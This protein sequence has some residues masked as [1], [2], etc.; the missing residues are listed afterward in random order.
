MGFHW[1]HIWQ[2]LTGGS[3]PGSTSGAA[4]TDA[5][6]ALL[7][8]L[9]LSKKVPGLSAGVLHRGQWWF[10]GG[11]G[12]A[13]LRKRLPVD[14]Q[15]TVFRVASIS[16][17]ITASALARMAA[18]GTLDL[19]A[20]LRTYVP[21]FPERHGTIT[22][23]QL[24]AHTGGIRAYRG[25]EFALNLP[26]SIADSLEIFAEDPLVFPPG[27]GYL[28]NSFDYV[29]L[30]LAMERAASKPF[31]ELVGDLVLDPLQMT[32]T[33]M[34]QPGVPQPGQAVFYHRKGLAFRPAIPVDTRYKLAGGGYLSTVGDVC[35]LGQAWLDGRIAAG[36]VL[37]PFLTSQ[38]AGG[39]PT[40]YGLGWQVSTDSGGRRFYGHIGNAV[41][42]YSNFFVYPDQ[43]LVICML[44]NCSV[45]D[46]QPDLDQVVDELHRSLPDTF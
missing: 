46:I 40:H 19:E 14:P 43:E 23:R 8:S 9:V 7:E 31:H 45:P 26:Y 42:A 25:K 33:T 41:G 22:L 10:C 35:R 28:Y 30:S 1:R 44:V 18:A 3:L 29:L 11:Y 20:D 6:R 32:R 17:P 27:Q 34:E 38:R 13:D 4:G 15:N 36:E 21:E 2:R 24:A 39:Q 12:Y 5:V 37:R 16:K